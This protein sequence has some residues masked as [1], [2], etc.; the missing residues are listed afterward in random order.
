MPE[1]TWIALH[2]GIPGSIQTTV[3][4]VP[5]GSG[6]MPTPLEVVSPV[7]VQGPVILHVNRE[8]ANSGIIG[9]PGRAIQRVREQRFA[10][11]PKLLGSV[12]GKMHQQHHRHRMASEPPANP[13]PHQGVLRRTDGQTVVADHA[14]FGSTDDMGSCV[15][16]LLT[17]DGVQLE[18]PVEQ[19]PCRNRTRP[20]HER[21]RAYRRRGRT[22]SLQSPKQAL[23]GKKP[24]EARLVCYRA[25]EHLVKVPPLGIVHPQYVVVC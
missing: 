4:R 5:P 17:G 18:K 24:G 13:T 8:C 23:S 15:L 7:P 21:C 12:D 11:S 9:R 3:E 2:A 6:S 22:L 20:S 1:S 25:I 16:G 10:K 14:P 19:A